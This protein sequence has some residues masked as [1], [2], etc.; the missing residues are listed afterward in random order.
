M[1]KVTL[2]E[3]VHSANSIF[4]FMRKPGYLEH[5]LREKRLVPRYCPEDIE[6]L[7]FL[8]NG[9]MVE[10]VAVLELCFCDIRLHSIPRS[11]L[12]EKSAGGETTVEWETHTKLYGEYGIA[13]SKKWA[14]SHNLQPV[15]YVNIE[16]DELAL[17]R[18]AL[19]FATAADDLDDSIAEELISRFCYM[20]PVTG[21]MLRTE[22][23][24]EPVCYKKNFQDECE[25]RFVPST[26]AL[27]NTEKERVIF[28]PI[29]KAEVDAISSNFDEETICHI[30][31]DFDY[32]DI[33]YIVVPNSSARDSLIKY[34]STELG[35]SENEDVMCKSRLI[36]K[37]LLLD[38][39]RKDM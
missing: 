5:A 10:K 34:M 15:H 1:A 13:F 3:S 29:S 19:T 22:E 6:Y 38:E 37:I 17:F 4:H 18:D 36:S 20:K 11:F 28:D 9:G 12:V 8:F 31:L 23:K 7:G 27:V 32:D 33:Q 39:L 26:K 24:D 35:I 14:L 16:S 25:W 2:I 21:K 30:S